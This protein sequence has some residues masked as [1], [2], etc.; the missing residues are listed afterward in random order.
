MSD[1]PFVAPTRV[2]RA[3]LVT[4]YEARR[5]FNAGGEVMVTERNEGPSV[6]VSTL[7]TTHTNKTTTWNYLAD[8]VRMWRSRY[9]GQRFYIV[10]RDK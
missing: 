10:R 8:Q 4:F 3:D 2:G 1:S 9:P 7:S 5:H 6:P